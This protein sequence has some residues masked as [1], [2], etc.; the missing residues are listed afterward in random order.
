MNS[1]TQIMFNGEQPHLRETQNL[2]ADHGMCYDDN[3]E[4]VDTLSLVSCWYCLPL[5]FSFFT[6]GSS[7]DVQ[8]VLIIS[9]ESNI[10]HGCK[11]KFYM[12]ICA[13]HTNFPLL[14]VLC[15]P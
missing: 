2:L 3:G 9:S 7:L 13:N 1:G 8:L 12:Y 5:G 15:F 4:F 10:Y 14:I 11:N 6:L